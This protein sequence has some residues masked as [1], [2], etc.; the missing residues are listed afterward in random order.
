MTTPKVEEYLDP[1]GRR[2][3]GDLWAQFLENQKYESIFKSAKIFHYGLPNLENEQIL[4]M[5][6]CNIDLI[7]FLGSLNHLDSLARLHQ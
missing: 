4:S 7:L 5:F 6:V 3:P 2:A 1:A